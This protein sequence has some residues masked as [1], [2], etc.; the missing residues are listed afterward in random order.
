M[1]IE[2][3]RRELAVDATISFGYGNFTE[4]QGMAPSPHRANHIDGAKPEGGNVV[5]LDGHVEWRP[6]SAMKN[7]GI[8]PTAW[9][10]W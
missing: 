9:F 5:F 8:A 2:P 3:A 6:F 7:R 10:W 4:V 1:A